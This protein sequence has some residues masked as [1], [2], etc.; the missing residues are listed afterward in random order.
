MY[1]LALDTRTTQPHSSSF[2]VQPPI[3]VV[4]G[5]KPDAKD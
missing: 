4:G 2:H 3:V 5:Q 1:S